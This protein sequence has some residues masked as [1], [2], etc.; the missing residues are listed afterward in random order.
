MDVVTTQAFLVVRAD[1]EMRVVR[2]KRG[3]SLRLDEIAFP[4]IVSIPKQWGRVQSTS[5]E[6]TM[7]EP[8]AAWVQVGD[9]EGAATEETD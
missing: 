4:L 3:L 6:L 8:P 7:P 5:I 9:G 1:G 2:G